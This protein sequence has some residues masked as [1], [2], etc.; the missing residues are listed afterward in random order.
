MNISTRIRA[1]L[2]RHRKISLRTSDL[3]RIFPEYDFSEHHTI[4]VKS[5]QKSLFNYAS[6]FRLR[7][8]PLIRFF[9]TLRFPVRRLKV[10]HST[11]MFDFEDFI[12]LS[13]VPDKEII[14]GLLGTFG[15]SDISHT[16][17]SPSEFIQFSQH[18]FY[19]VAVSIMVTPI[20][21]NECTLSTETR[22]K[23]TD[24]RTKRIFILY[25][26]SIRWTSGFLRKR[27]LR[28]I[29]RISDKSANTNV[30]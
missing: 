25:W 22:I 6:S 18:G 15:T 23:C 9:L 8:A 19:K 4:D 24:N 28:H 21:Q 3:D 29:K 17:R 27:M 5:D 1:V 30:P 16:M 7:D 13:D 26:L 20:T 14:R 10:S 12:V 11:E 2:E